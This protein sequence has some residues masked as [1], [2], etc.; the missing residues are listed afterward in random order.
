[1]S[2]VPRSRQH[3]DEVWHQPVRLAGGEAVQKRPGNLGDDESREVSRA[4]SRFWGDDGRYRLRGRVAKGV[5][6]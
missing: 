2:E 3:A 6:P 4:A 5:G 1:M